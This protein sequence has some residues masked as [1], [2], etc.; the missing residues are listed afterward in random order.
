M[1]WVLIK[2]LGGGALVIAA[3]ASFALYFRSSGVRAERAKWEELV[4][5]EKAKNE[6]ISKEL[7]EQVSALE[8][9]RNK[10]TIERVKTEVVYE[11]K[12]KTIFKSDPAI[13]NCH[14]KPEVLEALNGMKKAL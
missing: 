12:I 5:V 3:F 2:W 9:A 11:E 8:A 13:K 14:V 7:A 6:K 4:R 1:N 10:K